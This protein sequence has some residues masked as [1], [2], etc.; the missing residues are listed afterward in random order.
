MY[1]M[2]RSA[3]LVEVNPGSILLVWSMVWFV[4][5]LMRPGRAEH[6]EGYVISYPFAVLSVGAILGR[7]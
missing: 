4:E 6:Q 5:M 1:G 3:T 7:Y 2:V